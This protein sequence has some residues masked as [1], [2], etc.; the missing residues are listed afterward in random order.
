M[1]FRT[2]IDIAPYDFKIDYTTPGL[3]VGSCFADRIGMRMQTFKFPVTTNPCGV[4][5]NPYSVAHCIEMLEDGTARTQDELQTDGERWFSFDFHGSLAAR[6]PE[7]AISKIN[8]AIQ[9]GHE[10][11]TRADY[12]VLTFGTAWIYEIRKTGLPVANCHKMP[13]ST[14]AR[15]RLSVTEIVDRLAPLI[16]RLSERRHVILTVSPIRHLSDGLQENQLSKAVLRV[17]IDELTRLN[18]RTVYFPA[19]EIMNDDLRDY[20][21]YAADMTHPSEMAADYIWELF[22]KTVF[23]GQTQATMAEVNRIVTAVAHR[24]FD[25]TSPS[26][27]KFKQAMYRAT[28]TLSERH[29]EIDLSAELKYFAS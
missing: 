10:A 22:S 14:F 9:I 16:D 18:P 24:P 11:L 23:D 12:L 15:R 28:A 19:Y 5:Y 3:L 2:P 29:P 13:A 6:T 4:M 27:R 7:E 8:Q 26:H 21:F 17:A 20:R 25:P 1:Q